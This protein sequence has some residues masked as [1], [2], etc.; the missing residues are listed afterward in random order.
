MRT[1]CFHLAFF[2]FFL[3]ELY[4]SIGCIFVELSAAEVTHHSV[5]FIHLLL[6]SS[7]IVQTASALSH[8]V[9]RRL[10]GV[11]DAFAQLHRLQF[12][13]WYF[14]L[15]DRS[16]LLWLSILEFLSVRILLKTFTGRI[17]R[18]PH[19]F[20]IKLFSLLLSLSA[21]LN[22]LLDSVLRKFAPTL[23]TADQTPHLAILGWVL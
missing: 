18:R 11:A 21:S 3:A 4:V 8:M 17:S 5:I 19:L 14:T 12:P 9:I 16:R 10:L 15:L 23:R 13:F 20:N 1:T 7:S 6:C 22:M 2:T